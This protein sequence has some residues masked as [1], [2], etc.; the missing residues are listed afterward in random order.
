MGVQ[1]VTSLRNRRWLAALPVPVGGGLAA[2]S[3]AA[4]QRWRA[5]L[6]EAT[7]ADE[8]QLAGLAVEARKL[9]SKAV[10]QERANT[11]ERIN[12]W[13]LGALENG[14]KAAHTATKMIFAPGLPENVGHVLA[15]ASDK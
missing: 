14:A 9:E 4:W 6:A 12:K 10:Q 11:K 3:A 8:F 13:L 1:A 15:K 7:E 5:A 2:L